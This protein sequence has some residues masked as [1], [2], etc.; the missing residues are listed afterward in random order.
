MYRYLS[1][2]LSL[3]LSILSL[4]AQNDCN[5][6][7]ILND[8]G[9]DGWQGAGVS[10]YVETATTLYTINGATDTI[11]I[12]VIEGDSISLEYMSDPEYKQRLYM[13]LGRAT[14]LDYTLLRNFPQGDGGDIE[15]DWFEN[16]PPDYLD[17]FME[18][19]ECRD[20]MT[21]PV[22]E[23]A[24]HRL[25]IP[26]RWE[27]LPVVRKASE[28]DKEFIYDPEA[29]DAALTL[30]FHLDLMTWPACCSIPVADGLSPVPNL[31]NHFKSFWISIA[32]PLC[33]SQEVMIKP[34][35]HP[36]LLSK[37]FA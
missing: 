4:N 19:L 28:D 17:H 13:I 2:L 23:K 24:R 36:D 30:V 16:G 12:P 22:I 9:E 20:A 33:W 34:S 32:Q 15:W 35:N 29:W 14:S 25:R 26:P 10:F 5:Y 27:H 18:E 7:L 11:T 1:I 3:V 21:K 37:M 6:Q 31:A 8:A